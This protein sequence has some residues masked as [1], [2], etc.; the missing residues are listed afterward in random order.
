MLLECSLWPFM[1][2]APCHVVRMSFVAWSLS[3]CP[4]GPPGPLLLATISLDNACSFSRMELALDDSSWKPPLSLLDV[5]Y[6]FAT[7]Y[8]NCFHL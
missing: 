3:T 8:S 6:H 5:P 2:P 7:L 1:Y 4:A